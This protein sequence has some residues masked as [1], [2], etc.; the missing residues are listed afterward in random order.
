M[1][2]KVEKK[3]GKKARKKVWTRAV[4]E[5]PPPSDRGGSGRRCAAVLCL[6]DGKVCRA[7]RCGK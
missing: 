6:S 2:N 7:Y 1:G 5:N 3:A 4:A